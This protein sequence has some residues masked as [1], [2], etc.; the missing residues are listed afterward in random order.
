MKRSDPNPS[1]ET[2]GAYTQERETIPESSGF[3]NSLKRYSSDMETS[4]CDLSEYETLVAFE[5]K[6][7]ESESSNIKKRIK[8]KK[9]IIKKRRAL[10]K[11]VKESSDIFGVSPFAT[12][13]N[14]ESEQESYYTAAS[15]SSVDTHPRYKKKL[16][17]AN[18]KGIYTPT[19]CIVIVL[20]IYIYL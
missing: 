12:T 2:T 15:N 17:E 5:P 14:S 10:Y 1:K 11:K 18:L 19:N 3:A 4:T 9:A 16:D 7:G 20:L 6:R 13:P 8:D